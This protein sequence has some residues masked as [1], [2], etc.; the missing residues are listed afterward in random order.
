VKA[1]D[2]ADVAIV[3]EDQRMPSVEKLLQPSHD[4]L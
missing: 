3:Y 1:D 2:A 4:P